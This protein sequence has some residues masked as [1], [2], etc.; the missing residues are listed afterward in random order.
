VVTETYNLPVIKK[1]LEEA[2]HRGGEDLN[3]ELPGILRTAIKAEI[4]THYA[5][6]EGKPFTNIFIRRHRW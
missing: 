4:W 1:H 5:D 3:N 6:H 2:I